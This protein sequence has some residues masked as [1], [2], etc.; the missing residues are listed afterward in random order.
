MES[1]GSMSDLLHILQ[2]S[3]GVDR[4]GRGE[5]YRN[6]FVTGE[7]SVDHPI[8]M[9]AVER[10]LMHRRSGDALTGGDDLFTVTDAGKAWVAEHSPKPDRKQT[11]FDLPAYA[12]SVR[13][14]WAWAIIYGGKTV[15]N[16]VKRAITL[17]GMDKQR[18]LAIYASTGMTRDEYEGA[19]DFMASLGVQCPRPDDLV[20]GAIIGSVQVDGTTKDSDSPWFFGPLALLLSH[21]QPHD[22]IPCSGQLG[23]FLWGERRVDAVREPLPWMKAW[24]HSSARKKAAMLDDAIEG[25]LLL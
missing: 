1:Q 21:A 3:L 14:P 20:R 13:Q 6:H 18:Y 15:E 19:R 22:P 16:R 8:C 9:E 7:G 25:A 11:R 12:I 23:S 4:F 2:H 17:G 5:Q 10:G 24:P